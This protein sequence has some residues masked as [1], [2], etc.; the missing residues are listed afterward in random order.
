[1]DLKQ[2]KE[3]HERHPDTG[4]LKFRVD[5]RTNDYKEQRGIEQIRQDEAAAAGKPMRQNKIRAISPSNPCRQE[6]LDAGARKLQ[7]VEQGKVRP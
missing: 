7:T 3:Q 2:R 4:N 1:M 6:Y 5:V